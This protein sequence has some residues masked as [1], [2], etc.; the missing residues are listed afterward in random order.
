MIQEISGEVYAMRSVQGRG[1]EVAVKV[2]GGKVIRFPTDETFVLGEPV[3]IRMER[4]V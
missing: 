3:V 1:M 4:I 2:H